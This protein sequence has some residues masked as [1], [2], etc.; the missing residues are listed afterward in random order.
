MEEFAGFVAEELTTEVSKD[1][2]KLVV[3]AT[4]VGTQ[5]WWLSVQNERGI[6][7]NWLEY[8]ETAQL[9][10]EAGLNAIEE[11]GM[12]P[13]TNPEGFDYLFEDIS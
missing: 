1:G 11:E 8:F 2:V 6:N 10:I 4:R 5:E 12:E 3:I 7:T 9:A 13:F